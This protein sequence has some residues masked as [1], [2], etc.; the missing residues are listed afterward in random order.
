MLG[1]HQPQVT[2]WR[3]FHFDHDDSDELFR[4]IVATKDFFPAGCTPGASHYHKFQVGH[5]QDTLHKKCGFP[6]RISSVNVTKSAVSGVLVH[7]Y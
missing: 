7:V 6:F 2:N 4:G 3:K 5:K 1:H